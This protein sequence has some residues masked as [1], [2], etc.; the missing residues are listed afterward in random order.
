MN[1]IIPDFKLGYSNCLILMARDNFK[2][3]IGEADSVELERFCQM[4]QLHHCI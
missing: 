1:L 2:I 4:K 3:A